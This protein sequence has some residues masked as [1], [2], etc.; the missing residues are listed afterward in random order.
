MTETT[1]RV[2]IF[3]AGA[4]SGALA[5]RYYFKKKQKPVE[6]PASTAEEPKHAEPSPPDPPIE[7][8]LKEYN[9]PVP[10]QKEYD[11]QPIIIDE[12]QYMEDPDYSC[13]TLA[14]FADGALAEADTC[15]LMDDDRDSIVGTEFMKRFAEDDELDTVYVQNDARQFYFEITRD[16]RNYMDL[17]RANPYLMAGEAYDNFDDDEY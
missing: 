15:T 6:E 1:Q 7:E 13:M 10:P 5:T 4:L 2:L 11:D 3:L 16:P 8:V 17:V 12:S 14:Y 9:I